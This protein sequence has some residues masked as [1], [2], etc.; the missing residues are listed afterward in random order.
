MNLLMVVIA[1]GAEYREQYRRFFEPSHREYCRRH[2][3]DVHVVE[4]HIDPQGDQAPV[5]LQRLLICSLP[6]AAAYSHVA[7]VDADILINPAAPSLLDAVGQTDA[8]AIVDEFSQPSPE[9]RLRVQKR[10]GWELQAADYYELGGFHL[11]TTQVLNTA[12]M[13]AQPAKHRALFEALYERGKR[14]MPGN[15]RGLHYEPALVGSA[16][17]SRSL[18]KV[19]DNRWNAL[20]PIYLEGLKAG[21]GLDLHVWMERIML[22]VPAHRRALFRRFYAENYFIH[23][24]G[25]FF[26]GLEA[27]MARVRVSGS[28]AAE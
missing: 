12:V 8:V 7:H 20:F 14:E 24:A 10:R 3:F 15:P 19:L 1:V 26:H 4:T 27:E 22:N 13:V 16:L 28:P 25:G 2:G 6:Q 21:N 23:L 9:L 11:E 18:V 5:V 17:Q